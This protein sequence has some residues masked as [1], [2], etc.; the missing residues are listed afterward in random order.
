MLNT[1]EQSK[2]SAVN[3]KLLVRHKFTADQQKYWQN[4]DPPQKF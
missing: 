2:P 4:G 1:A 3:P